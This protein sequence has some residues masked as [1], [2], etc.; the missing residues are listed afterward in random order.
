MKRDHEIGDGQ[1]FDYALRVLRLPPGGT[2]RESPRQ[3]RN[4]PQVL[5]R[6]IELADLEFH[7][8]LDNIDAKYYHE[9]AVPAHLM[10]EEAEA[11]HLSKSLHME[12]VSPGILGPVTTH[13]RNGVYKVWIAIFPCG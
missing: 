4:P 8:L 3:L 12:Q 10:V 2:P 1:V 11:I 7:R 6:A 13:H 5:L 9:F